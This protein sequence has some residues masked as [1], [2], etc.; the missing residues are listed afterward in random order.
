M[1]KDHRGG[2]DEDEKEHICLFIQEGCST[3]TVRGAVEGSTS[4]CYLGLQSGGDDG[5]EREE[6]RRLVLRWGSSSCSGSATFEE[7]LVH[8]VWSPRGLPGKMTSVMVFQ[9]EERCPG[10]HVVERGFRYILCRSSE[11]CQVPVAEGCTNAECMGTRL[12][13]ALQ[14]QGRVES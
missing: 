10:T 1:T 7:W 2:C 6:R 4:P 11:L 14:V 8:Y 5:T 13:R 12:Y 9:E 3:N